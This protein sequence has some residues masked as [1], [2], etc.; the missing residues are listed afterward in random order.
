M[1][2]RSTYLVIR[3]GQFSV[4]GETEEPSQKDKAP[5]PSNHHAT[6]SQ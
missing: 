4:A 5:K 6:Q 1:P 2:R 3:G